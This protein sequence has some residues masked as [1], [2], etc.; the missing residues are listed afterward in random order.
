[1][2][3]PGNGVVPSLTPQCGS[4]SILINCLQTGSSYKYC[5]KTPIIQLNTIDLH[6]IKWL[7]VLLC[8]TN[9][10]IKHQSFVYT[11]LNGQ[12]VLFLIIQF[13]IWHLFASVC[14][15]VLFDSKTGPYQMLPLQVRV[16]L[17]AMAINGYSAFPKA[18][19]LE[20]HHQIV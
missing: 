18:P 20:L 8:N 6:T 3:N 16:D 17:R 15:T 1:M 12:R 5:Y 19:G 4:Y 2:N 7:Q 11:Q 9:N 13:N 10:S 14:Q